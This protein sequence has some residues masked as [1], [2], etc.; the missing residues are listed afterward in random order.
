[1]I[2]GLLY[3]SLDLPLFVTCLS[4]PLFALLTLKSQSFKD[5]C[6]P[7][8]LHDGDVKLSRATHNI[9]ELYMHQSL[10][11]RGPGLQVLPGSTVF[12]LH[13]SAMFSTVIPSCGCK[14]NLI[15]IIIIVVN[16]TP[17]QPFETCAYLNCY[18]ESQTE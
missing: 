11:D 10:W 4:Y 18:R 6:T 1:M 3:C 15:I 5:L 17:T 2:S 7:G 14:T 13:M 16:R 9:K 8:I 12:F